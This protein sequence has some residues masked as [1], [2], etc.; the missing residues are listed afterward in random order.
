MWSKFREVMTSNTLIDRVQYP[1]LCIYWTQ[2][3]RFYANTA[4]LREVLWLT[5]LQ[6]RLVSKA[7]D[8]IKGKYSQCSLSPITISDQQ[9]YGLKYCG[10]KYQYSLYI[11][12]QFISVYNL[13]VL[14]GAQFSYPSSFQFSSRGCKERYGLNILQQFILLC[15]LLY[16]CYCLFYF[17]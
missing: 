17:L 16:Y 4:Q 15:Y 5:S 8:L 2:I 14:R 11:I 10:G 9:L 1:L 3:P 12:C 6:S 7:L 13:T